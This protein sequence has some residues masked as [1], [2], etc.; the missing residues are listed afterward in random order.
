MSTASVQVLITASKALF[1]LGSTRH[2]SLSAAILGRP[3][4]S[5]GEDRRAFLD[6]ESGKALRYL[7]SPG[8]RARLAE[9][10]P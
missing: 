8:R 4:G 10:T 9:V 1:S 2:S 3:P 7:V 5:R 6:L